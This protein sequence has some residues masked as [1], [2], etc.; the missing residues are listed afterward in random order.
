MTWKGRSVTMQVLGADLCGIKCQGSL[1]FAART[2][3]NVGFGANAV[4]LSPILGCLWGNRTLADGTCSIEG[5]LKAKG[6]QDPLAEYSRGRLTIRADNGRIYRWTLLS[7]LFGALNVMEWFKGNPLDLN[8]TGFRYDHMTVKGD[9]R[10]GVLHLAEAVVDGPSMKIVGE[11]AIDTI[12]GQVDLTVVVAPMKTVDTVLSAIPILGHILTGES[13][14]FVSVPLKVQGPIDD[15]S[16]TPFPPSAVGNG[17]LG[18][19]RRT[20]QAPVKVIS[21]GNSK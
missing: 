15:P 5:T 12:K 4:A 6:R 19:L 14:T 21:P 2:T 16:V 8:S 7:K 17:L 20:I 18:I 13:G 10:N 1:S 3:I 11:G 9:V